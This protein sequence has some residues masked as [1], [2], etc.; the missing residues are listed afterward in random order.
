MPACSQIE[1]PMMGLWYELL[2]I[3]SHHS[4][5]IQTLKYCFFTSSP[6]I[7]LKLKNNENSEKVRDSEAGLFV[8]V[9]AIDLVKCRDVCVRHI[10]FLG[11]ELNSKFSERIVLVL[12]LLYQTTQ[13]NAI[14]IAYS[15]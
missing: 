6:S 3:P 1:V 10:G 11:L 15:Q 12:Y 8:I 7:F 5:F 4:W 14:H 2:L 13:C 9:P